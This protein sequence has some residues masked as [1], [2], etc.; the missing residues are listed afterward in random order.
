M[1]LK[2][3]KV[4]PPTEYIKLTLEARLPAVVE[5][6]PLPTAPPDT[7]HNNDVSDLQMLSMHAVPRTLPDIDICDNPAS[8]PYTVSLNEPE[9]T[10]FAVPSILEAFELYVTPLVRLPYWLP[11]VI[12]TTKL[13]STPCGARHR[14]H[15]SDSHVERSQPLRPTLDDPVYVV[16]PI[17]APSMVA[18][19]EPVEAE[20]ALRRELPM[21]PSKVTTPLVLPD[22]LPLLTTIR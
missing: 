1:R 16:V 9:L 5:N 8:E 12:E 17:L 19:I 18:L 21:Y 20:F 3:L 6:R 14:T 15:V 10:P 13:R 11:D 22:P 2:P 4:A 7:R